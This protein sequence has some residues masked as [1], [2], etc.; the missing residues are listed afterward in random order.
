MTPERFA[1]IKATYCGRDA[2]ELLAE[3][4]RLRAGLGAAMVAH[5][6]D[7]YAPCETLF[8]GKCDCFADGHN[9]RID[10]LLRGE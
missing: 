2:G 9:A 5:E 10:A 6:G 7:R 8:G 4:D 3:V 1:E